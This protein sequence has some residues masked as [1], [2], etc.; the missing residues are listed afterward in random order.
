MRTVKAKHSLS[1]RVF[2]TIFLVAIVAIAAFT[3]AG[4]AYL[5]K[6]LVESTREELCEEA[7]VVA[8]ALEQSPSS[9]ELLESLN[10]GDS[11]LTLLAQDGTVLY[12]NEEDPQ[13]MGNHASRPEVRE[14]V[15]TGSGSAER[16]SS[17]I[18]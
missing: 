12:D 2:S 3:L 10:L 6:N 5:Q 7:D 16:A 17:T 14:A 1:H 9:L 11:R 4:T 13:V 8:A 18:G 15:Q